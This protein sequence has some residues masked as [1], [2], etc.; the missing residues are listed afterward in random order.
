[1]L[2]KYLL[3]SNLMICGFLVGLIW[4]VQVVHY[5]I[6]AKVGKSEFEA[7]H[8]QHVKDTGKVVA[9]PMLI[10]L[11][12]AFLM[13]VLAGN[14]IPLWQNILSFALVL[15][16]WLQTFF[17]FVPLH[18]KLHAADPQMIAQLVSANGWRTLFWSLRFTLL[19]W[20]VFNF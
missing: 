20:I 15:I 4:F 3:F 12:L 11:G 10:E 9:L 6:F 18:G 5:P 8:A 14:Q 19:G 7:Y 2:V 13:L 17:Y 16:V 1:M